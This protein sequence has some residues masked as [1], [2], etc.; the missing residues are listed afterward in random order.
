ME[1]EWYLHY[2]RAMDYNTTP[3]YGYL[4]GLFRSSMLG[5]KLE[6]ITL[7]QSPLDCDGFLHGFPFVAK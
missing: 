5:Q 6:K 2:V 4:I 7:E 1:M 3:D